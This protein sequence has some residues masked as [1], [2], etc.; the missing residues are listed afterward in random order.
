MSAITFPN[1]SAR[2]V[3][4]AKQTL[5]ASDSELSLVEITSKRQSVSI[6]LTG[7]A[8]PAHD[9][10]IDTLGV[11]SSSEQPN[12]H[13]PFP[14]EALK[15]MG[16]MVRNCAATIDAPAT[17]TSL[18]TLARRIDAIAASRPKVTPPPKI[19]ID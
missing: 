10:T 8:P 16:T 19:I 2:C 18:R 15:R 17:R 5:G 14:A 11:A 9:L 1:V 12:F 6:K 13:P 4:S 3:L 7:E